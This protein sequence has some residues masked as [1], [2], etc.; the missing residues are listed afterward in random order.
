MEDGAKEDP[1]QSKEP[2]FLGKAGWV[3]KAPSR[4]L[5]SY[6]DRFVHVEKTEIVVYE[7]ENQQ[8]CLERLDLENYD[9]CHELKSPFKKKH[10]LILIRS[11]KPGNKVHDVKFQ[12]QTAEEKE[13]WIKALIDGINRAKNKI[14]DEVTVDESINLEHVTR[15]RPKGN[16]N[17]RPPTRIHMKEIADVSSDGILRLDLDLENARM[18]NGT[19]RAQIDG[20]ET[21]KEAIKAPTP[22][23]NASES[24]EKQTAEEEAPTEPQV[25][26]QRKVIKPPMPPTKEAKSCSTPEDEPDKD[27]GAVNKVLKPPMPPSKEAKPCASHVED[28]TEEVKDKKVEKS[29][30][31]RKK[32]GP[33]P[34]P[35]NKPNSSDSL[36]NLT[37]ASQSRP[38]SHPPTPP[39][40]KRKPFNPAV[41]PDQEARGGKEEGGEEEGGEEEGGEEQGGEGEVAETTAETNEVDQS[42]A[43]E[44]LPSVRDDEPESPDTEGQV[45]EEESE[46]TMGSD[47]SKASD[48]EPQIP[49]ETLGRSPSP[50]LLHEK[51]M[52]EGQDA[53][54]L[55]TT[56]SDASASCPAAD[57][58]QPK[59]QVPS[60]LVYLNDPV[61]DSL[62]LSPLLCHFPGEKKKKTEEKSVD[63]GQHSDVDSEG[64]GSEDT[65]VASAAASRGSHAGRDVLDASEDDIQIPV[66]SR[67]IKAPPKPQVRPKV[68]PKVVP[69]RRS[70]PTLPL[71]P[72]TKARSTSIGDLL[73]DSSVRV[74]AG[75]HTSA[76]AGGDDFMKLETEVALEMKKTRELLSRVSQLQRGGDEEGKTED[77]LAKAMAKLKKADHVLKEVKKLKIAHNLSNRKSW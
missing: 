33:P 37:E 74:E 61:S 27:D 76:A 47:E 16:R 70:G 8:N 65:L 13:A 14:F 19:H 25:S 22:P 58:A 63:S 7:N 46:E 69:G 44:A 48:N 21:P 77:L 38:K 11:H 41:E 2:T 5:A 10:R 42:I 9:K 39:S 32:T 53:T 3:K 57:E 18:P 29:P 75:Q 31:A 26:P 45:S 55:L 50:L 15:T 49:I 4:L 24:A 35:P 71:K 28:T 36:S 43:K 60:V 62:R 34:S 59:S 6:K 30:D 20:T 51:K 73:S 54:E 64:F 40:K 1:A 68:R 23:S 66:S 56:G 12:A 17:R 52:N 67:P 72:S